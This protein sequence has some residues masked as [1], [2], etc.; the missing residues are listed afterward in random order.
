MHI[1]DILAEK[2]DID[3]QKVDIQLK[4]MAIDVNDKTRKNLLALYDAVKPITYLVVLL[5]NL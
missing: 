3:V 2:A 4:I 5:S 1:S